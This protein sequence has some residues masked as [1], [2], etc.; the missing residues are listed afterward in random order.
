MTTVPKAFRWARIQAVRHMAV[1]ERAHLRWGETTITEIV[2]AHTARAV[3][4]VPFTQPAEALSGADWV[5]WWVD[6][7][8]AYGMLVQAKRVTVTN[9]A[10]NFDFGYSSQR[11]ALHSAAAALGLLPVYALYLG[12]GD[13]RKWES[14]TDI[15]RR[16]RCIHCIKRTVSLMPALLADERFVYDATSTY[17]QSV[18]LEDLWTGSPASVPLRPA[19]RNQL[20]PEL[21]DFLRTQ[22]DG[23]RAVT[24]SM[25]D[26][27]LRA[28]NNQFAAV[29]T[30]LTRNHNEDHDR[31]GSV[32]GDFPDDIGHWGLRYFAHTLE[33][34]LQAPPPYVLGIMSGGYDQDRLAMNMPENVAG[35]IVVRVP[36]AE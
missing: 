17:R 5:W 27:V 2:T 31:L 4:V 9:T 33:P 14:C 3:N 10:W 36:H 11:E 29:S 32:F 13:Y 22:Q 26:L 35:I 21:S 19:L 25:I 6:S 34:L 30:S 24:R 23:T 20:P 12:T 8:G 18:A 16:V 28:R 1:C 7:T 15:H